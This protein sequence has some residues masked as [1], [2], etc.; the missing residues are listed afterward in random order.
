MN[1]MTEH[2]GSHESRWSKHLAIL[3]MSEANLLLESAAIAE[4]AWFRSKS[5]ASLTAGRSSEN[6]DLSN[7]NQYVRSQL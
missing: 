4:T 7:I 2:H 5:R 6:S 1:N 3:G